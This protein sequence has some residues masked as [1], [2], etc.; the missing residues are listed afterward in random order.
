MIDTLNKLSNQK[1]VKFVSTYDF[2]TLYTNIPHDKLIKTLNSVIDFAFKGRAKTKCLSMTTAYLTVVNLL[3][4]L[5][6]TSTLLKNSEKC[7]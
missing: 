6:L 2:A 7:S 3:N 4:I 1:A 5:Y